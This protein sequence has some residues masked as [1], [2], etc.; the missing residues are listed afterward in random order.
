MNAT[1]ALTQ[2]RKRWGKTAAVKH[3]PGRAKRAHHNGDYI[4]GKI[5]GGMF[6]EVKGDGTTW[7][8]AFVDADMKWAIDQLRYRLIG[9]GYK[10]QE[11]GPLAT[12][13]D[14]RTVETMTCDTCKS[15]NLSYYPAHREDGTDYRAFA[16]CGKCGHH[17]EFST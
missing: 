16:V 14:R 11:P 6:F 5:M 2:A 12:E 15:G 8:A 1:Q 13:D 3:E 7:T 17:Q 10:W 4:V 9:E